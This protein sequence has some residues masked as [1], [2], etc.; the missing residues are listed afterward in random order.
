ME[1]IRKLL[2]KLKTDDFEKNKQKSVDKFAVQDVNDEFSS[3]YKKANLESISQMKLKSPSNEVRKGSGKICSGSTNPITSNTIAKQPVETPYY[4]GMK[5][6]SNTIPPQENYN[7][8][9]DMEK[10]FLDAFYEQLNIANLSPSRIK[11]TRMSNGGFSVDYLGLGYIGKINLCEPP[12]TYAVIKKGNQ[13]A[14]KVFCSLIEAN[15]F[16][17]NSSEY[18]VETRHKKQSIYM[19]Y[20]RGFSTIKDLHDISLDEC[21]DLIPYWIRYIKYCKRN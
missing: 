11:L 14:T 12:I 10:Q 5:I 2:G 6:T 1:L 13:R 21:I 8:L 9:S 18:I 15:L 4:L 19:Q 7:V 16:A 17:S 20:L 3:T